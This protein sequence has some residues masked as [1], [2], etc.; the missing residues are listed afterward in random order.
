MIV[1]TGGAGFIGANIVKALND[2]GR[3]DI[4][5]VDDLSDGTKFVNLAD[6]TIADYLVKDDFL[7]R[8]Q[9]SLMGEYAELPKIE[10]IFHEDNVPE[11]WAAFTELNAEM[12]PTLPVWARSNMAWDRRLAM[13]MG[14]VIW[15]GL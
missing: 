5:V 9:S 6:L 2:R 12:A 3:T 10:A 13:W 7:I 11:E 15:I 8:V 14:T 1:V 4:L